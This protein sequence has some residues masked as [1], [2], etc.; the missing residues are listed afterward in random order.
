MLAIGIIIGFVLG[1]IFAVVCMSRLVI[2]TLKV[3]RDDYDGETYMYVE[4]DRP[5]YP[6]D[7]FAI[8]RVDNSQV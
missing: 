5:Y 7:K 6:R 8:M 1:F 2:G 4:L 3:T